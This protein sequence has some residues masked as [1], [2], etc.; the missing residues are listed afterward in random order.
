[1]GGMFSDDRAI[2]QGGIYLISVIILAMIV[3]IV[4][5]PL[6]AVL[7]PVLT[8]IN[9]AVVAQYP[10]MVARIDTGI[11]IFA[12]LPIITIAIAALYFIMRAIKK[13]GY[14]EYDR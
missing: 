11:A 8:A 7:P 9:P 3:Y 5:L 13:Q 6:L 10:R 14:S 12:G 4:F 1:M 2:M